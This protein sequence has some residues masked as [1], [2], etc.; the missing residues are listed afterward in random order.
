[1]VKCRWLCFAVPFFRYPFDIPSEAFTFLRFK[2]AFAAIQ[3]SIVHL[4]AS[5][6]SPLA[7]LIVLFCAGASVPVI[8]CRVAWCGEFSYES[9]QV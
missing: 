9:I 5:L 6:L 3:A 2:Q 7:N 4:Q 8:A 1:M